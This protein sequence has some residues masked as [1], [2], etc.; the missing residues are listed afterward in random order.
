MIVLSFALPVLT[1]FF[2]NSSPNPSGSDEPP[3]LQDFTLPT[4]EGGDIRLT[5]R[6]ASYS[7]VILV[8]HRGFECAACRAQLSEIQSGY[9]DLRIEGAEVLAI[10]LDNQLNTQ[11]L[12]LQAG[13]RFPMLYDESGVVAASY[14]VRDELTDSN[15]T[16]AVFILDRDLKQVINAVGTV[17]DQLLPVAVILDVLREA[18]GTNPSGGTPS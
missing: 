8:F 10:G 18:H 6:V 15:F 5:E 9:D 1:P 13:L 2:S 4:S 7:N 3:S 16:T 14:G 11:R 17:D 12:T